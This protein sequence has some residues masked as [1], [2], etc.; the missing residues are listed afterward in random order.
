[1]EKRIAPREQKAQELRAM[2]EG[3][4]EAHSGGE[5]LSA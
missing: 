3:E 4:T 1:M 2:L 5:L